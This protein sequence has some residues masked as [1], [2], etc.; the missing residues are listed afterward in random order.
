MERKS[1]HKSEVRETVHRVR[2]LVGSAH[3]G[4][5]LTAESRMLTHREANEEVEKN[6]GGITMVKY[7]PFLLGRQLF[8]SSWINMGSELCWSWAS[9]KSIR[10]YLVLRSADRLL[11]CRAQRVVNSNIHVPWALTPTEGC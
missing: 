3:L 7:L 11:W 8:A 9:R 1:M 6:V 10:I 5:M 4:N 2:G